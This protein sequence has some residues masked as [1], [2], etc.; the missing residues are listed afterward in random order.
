MVQ[1]KAVFLPMAMGWRGLFLN[2]RHLQLGGSSCT[3]KGIDCKMVMVRGHFIYINTAKAATTTALTEPSR[4][5]RFTTT[6]RVSS[7]YSYIQPSNNKTTFY[8][9]LLFQE[10]QLNIPTKCTPEN[11]HQLLPQSLPIGFPAN[12]F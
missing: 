12:V 2:S 10:H 8:I 9:Y 7:A 5:L 4:L 1:C 3:T 6:T 11:F